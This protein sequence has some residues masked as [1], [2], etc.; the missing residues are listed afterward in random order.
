MTFIAAHLHMLMHEG[1]WAD[2]EAYV[3]GFV[4]LADLS[5]L[6]STV[7]NRIRI[8]GVMAKFSAGKA[9]FV[10]EASFRRID[11]AFLAN[12]ELHAARRT[13]LSMRSDRKKYVRASPVDLAI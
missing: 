8:T 11:A 3:G 12:P 10:D 5:P 7:L 4:D 9:S 1:R 13:L 2:A 6:A